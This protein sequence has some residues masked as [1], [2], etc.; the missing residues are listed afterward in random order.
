MNWIPV[1]IGADCLDVELIEEILC[2]YI[3][4]NDFAESMLNEVYGN[5]KIGNFLVPTG[6]ALRR[7]YEMEDGRE[8]EDIVDDILDSEAES[9]KFGL[10][11]DGFYYSLSYK[12]ILVDDEEN[13]E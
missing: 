8:W 4:A 2:E 13:G 11:N 7:I 6:T 3:D 12:F 9:I 1:E 10:E 5:S